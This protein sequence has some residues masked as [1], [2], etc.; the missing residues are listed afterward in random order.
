MVSFTKFKTTFTKMSKNNAQHLFK[1]VDLSTVI[2]LHKKF[3]ENFMFLQFYGARTRF[4]LNNG[5]DSTC[6][7]KITLELKRKLLERECVKR[8]IAFIVTH[9]ACQMLLYNCTTF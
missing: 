4:N 2:R 7:F 5:E 6:R 9:N 3:T 1:V 8:F